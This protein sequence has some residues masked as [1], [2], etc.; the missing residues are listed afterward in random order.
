MNVIGNTRDNK[1][2]FLQ[3][4]TNPVANLNNAN[5]IMVG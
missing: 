2:S 5:K 4:L 3:S 1:Y